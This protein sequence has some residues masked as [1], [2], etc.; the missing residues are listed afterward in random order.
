M[1]ARIEKFL[2][3][4]ELASLAQTAPRPGAVSVLEQCRATVRR[5]AVVTN[6]STEVVTAFR[7][8]IACSIWC[9]GCTAATRT[10]TL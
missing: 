2:T 3:A 7:H 8:A 4:A 5:V 10:T 6:D 1:H 9:R